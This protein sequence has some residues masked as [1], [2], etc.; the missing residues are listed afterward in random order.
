MS[1][2]SRGRA[3]FFALGDWNAVCY[4][5]GRKRKASTLRK[6]WQG[7][8]VCPEHWEAR[9]PQDFVRNVPDVITAPWAQP[10][11]D[12]FTATCTFCGTSAVPGLMEP[13][14][15]TPGY[16]NPLCVP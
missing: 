13:G 8:Y 9:Q 10:P 14:C 11:S 1:A 4:E 16:L 6:H 7:Y 5:C 12:T 3:D 2:F 15:V